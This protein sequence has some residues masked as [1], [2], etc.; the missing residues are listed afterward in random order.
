MSITTNVESSNPLM[1]GV[2]DTTVCDKV[3]WRLA[4]D[5]WFSSGTHVSSAKKNWRYSWNIVESGVKHHNPKPLYFFC[6][7][8]F[9]NIFLFTIVFVYNDELSPRCIFNRISRLTLVLYVLLTILNSNVFPEA[10]AEVDTL[11]E[12]SFFF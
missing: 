5:R 7:L 2:L 11:G 6:F 9:Q 12:F 1:R 4:A 10:Q 3:C 8:N